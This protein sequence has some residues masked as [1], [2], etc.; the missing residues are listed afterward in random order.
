MMLWVTFSWNPLF[1]QSLA[2][3]SKN[4]ALGKGSNFIVVTSLS[5]L[6]ILS[7]FL[8]LYKSVLPLLAAYLFSPWE[9]TSKWI[10]FCIIFC[11]SHSSG[12][13]SDLATQENLIHLL[14]ELGAATLCPLLYLP[15]FPGSDW[16]LLSS[17]LASGGEFPLYFSVTLVASYLH[18]SLF[19]SF[20]DLIYLFEREKVE[21]GREQD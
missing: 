3:G 11:Q 7:W 14:L 4:W 17:V 6:I 15:I 10:I 1:P 20:W 18:I 16:R 19:I 9:A 13:P 2:S 21:R 12:F 5:L 8:W